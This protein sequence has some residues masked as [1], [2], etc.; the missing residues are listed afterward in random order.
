MCSVP[1]AAI[2]G[3]HTLSGGWIENE[4]AAV[5]APVVSMA[6]VKIEHSQDRAA[7]KHVEGLRVGEG[8]TTS[9]TGLPNLVTR[10]G[11]RVLRTRSRTARQVALNLEIAISSM[12]LAYT[13]TIVN[14]AHHP[15]HVDEY[16]NLLLRHLASR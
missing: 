8:G 6:A 2:L 10:I 5:R 9:A 16:T 11:R 1:G 12:V 4:L 7:R 3:A 13:M 15:N 14:A